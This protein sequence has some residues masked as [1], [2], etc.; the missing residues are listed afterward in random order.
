MKDEN[1]FLFTEFGLPPN[2]KQAKELA[3]IV[4]A[5][6]NQQKQEVDDL[7]TSLE[8]SNHQSFELERN[9]GITMSAPELYKTVYDTF[10]KVCH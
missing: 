2:K 3:N 10:S 5:K 4:L 9:T 6:M 7:K 1:C 8:K